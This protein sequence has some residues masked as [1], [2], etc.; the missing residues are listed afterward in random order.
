MRSD[1]V[2]YFSPEIMEI[3]LRML[4]GL[5]SAESIRRGTRVF[6]VAGTLLITIH[7]RSFIGS[8][9]FAGRHRNSCFLP[10]IHRQD[11]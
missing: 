4:K 10:I 6:S 2:R 11:V 1:H 3:F 8:F 7:F 9:I 5:A